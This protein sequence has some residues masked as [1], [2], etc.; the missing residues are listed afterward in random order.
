MTTTTNQTTSSGQ[1][2]I[3]DLGYL[4]ALIADKYERMPDA[5]K[6]LLINALEAGATQIEIVFR[7]EKDHAFLTVCDNGFGMDFAKLNEVA[8]NICSSA[9]RFVEKSTGKHALAL[10][11]AP[12]RL[13]AVL[14]EVISRPMDSADAFKLSFPLNEKKPNF[15][16][17]PAG[18]M[19]L[20][21]HGTIIRFA[22]VSEEHRA[23]LSRCLSQSKALGISPFAKYCSAFFRTQLLGKASPQCAISIEVVGGSRAGSK[24]FVAP[25]KY[26]GAAVNIDPIKLPGYG[27]VQFELYVKPAGSDGTIS[28]EHHTGSLENDLTAL[29]V[30]N[31]E[32]WS[33]FTGVITAKGLH[34]SAEGRIALTHKS[35]L[36]LRDILLK[37]VE[38]T[39]KAFYQQTT[40]QRLTGDDLRDLRQ[41]FKRVF[42]ESLILGDSVK[43]PRVQVLSAE[44]V[45][46]AGLT[47]A[48]LGG[49]GTRAPVKN[50]GAGFAPYAVPNLE[51]VVPPPIDKTERQALAARNTNNL[52][53]LF[54]LFL[55]AEQHKPY[56]VHKGVIEINVGHPMYLR[57]T[58]PANYKGRRGLTS[59]DLKLRWTVTMTCM[60]IATLN[61]PLNQYH[62]EEIMLQ[63]MVWQAEMNLYL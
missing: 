28:V 25:V 57:Y 41:I 42:G 10:V 36:L 20:K 26:M 50:T 23:E 29:P 34:K 32:P 18:N 55:E 24:E 43:L 1:L 38:P 40:E 59:F 5:L 7:N 46:T 2:D 47:R 53:W 27:E 58:N 52:V 37:E 13:G 3:A 6:E 21:D 60:L 19:G 22:V 33:S 51:R 35:W 62:P 12:I 45:E 16:V 48:N 17:E 61:M 4:F 30:F 49:V 14:L 44:G 39:L 56:R 54:L 8:Q 63:A 31:R 9:K 15:K 11:T